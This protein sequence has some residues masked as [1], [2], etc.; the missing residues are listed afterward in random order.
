MLNET[1][2]T[3]GSIINITSHYI[4]DELYTGGI[5]IITAP[6]NNNNMLWMLLPLLA[7]LLLMEFYFGR[8][9]DEELGWN[10]AFGNA[11]VLC[12]VAIDLFRHLY[13]SST[14]NIIEYILTINDVK[15][16]IPLVIAS[17]AIILIFI[18][19]FHFLPEK[20]A[21]AL[22]SPAYINLIG[23][24][25]IILIYTDSILLNWTTIFA[26]VI[27]FIMVNLITLVLYYIIPKYEPTISKILTIKDVETI[28][29]ENTEF[30]NKKSN[31]KE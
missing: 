21:Y 11:L 28:N 14:A 31:K 1:I 25:G 7:T 17:L 23:L 27:I 4:T 20:I 2:S 29:A 12:F 26:C 5:N 9:K 16:I 19:F 13:G 6:F 18:D 30:K 8:Y 3:A 10:T 15:I 22:S 24:L